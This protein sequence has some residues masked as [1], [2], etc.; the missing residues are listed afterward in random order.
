M[1]LEEALKTS[2]K[3]EEVRS[4]G[5]LLAFADDMLVMSNCK[6]EI[7]QIVSEL[8]NLQIDWNLRMNKKKSEILTSEDIKEIGGVRCTTSVKYLGVKV[9]VD[10]K[11]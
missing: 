10:K 7:E 3:L 9:T 6:H 4:R 11:E 8:A 2:K 1:Y 5:D